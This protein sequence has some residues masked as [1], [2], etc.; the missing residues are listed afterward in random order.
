MSATLACMSRHITF[1]EAQQ[2]V[3]TRAQLL[4]SGLLP[5]NIARAV[6]AGEL[7][8]LQRNRYVRD[9]LWSG[10][11]PES[12]HRIE[13]SAALGEMRDGGG[14][15][16]YDSAGVLWDFSLYRH[17]PA[18][19]HM[20]MSPRERMSSRPGLRR[21]AEAL[22][23]AD[24]ATLFGVRCTTAERTI[25]D[26]VRTL[27][28]EA[29]VA[30]ADAGLRQT[31]MR[32]DAYDLDGAEEWRQRMLD[33]CARAA[34]KRGIRQAIETITFADGRADLP[35]ESVS[36]LQLSRLGFRHLLPQVPVRGPSGEEYRVDIGIE[37]ARTFFEYDGVGKYLD[38]AMR[39]GR[40]IE[41]VML[42]E[43]RREDWIRGTTQW[44]F[45]RVGSPH[46]RTAAALASRLAAFG[47]TLPGR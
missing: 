46:I 31:A 26:L 12:R 30:V 14:T 40:T 36:R 7:R 38:A 13:V 44:R 32:G 43:K 16:S 28:P 25:F 24:I 22:P 29:A 34:G 42:D 11:W 1:I 2:A 20:S 8:R 15:A 23:D 21:H 39:T 33:R 3:S 27:G 35:G 10:L 19:V 37:D 17:V 41:Q 4:G 9:E 6:D 18:A 45:V 5:R 47:V